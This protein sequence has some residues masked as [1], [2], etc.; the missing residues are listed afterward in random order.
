MTAP[1]SRVPNRRGL[2][3]IVGSS[4]AMSRLRRQIVLVARVSSNI[5]IT[6]DGHRKRVGGLGDSPGERKIGSEIRVRQLRGF[7]GRVV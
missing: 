7:A 5:L 4:A 1:A 2:D 3:A 6:G